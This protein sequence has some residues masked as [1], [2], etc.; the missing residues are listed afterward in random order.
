MRFSGCAAA[1]APRDECIFSPPSPLPL[2]HS[3]AAGGLVAA[4]AA[5]HAP[6]ITEL[7]TII[8]PPGTG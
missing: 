5:Y 1:R 2:F 4:A 7:T 6:G 8:G 3:A